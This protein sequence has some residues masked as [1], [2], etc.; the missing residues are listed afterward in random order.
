M[1]DTWHQI[2]LVAGFFIAAYGIHNDSIFWL[3]VGFTI[4]AVSMETI[5]EMKIKR[6][7]LLK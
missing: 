3:V 1:K 5:M 4:F 6:A 2:G 7:L